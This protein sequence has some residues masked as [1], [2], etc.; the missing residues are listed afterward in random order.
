[1]N[2]T[3]AEATTAKTIAV[4]FKYVAP[5]TTLG[6]VEWTVNKTNADF[7]LPLGDI[8]A[9]LAGSTD[10]DLPSVVKVGS[11]TWADGKAL[12]E[13]TITVNGVKYGKDGTA[14]DESWITTID[15]STL[16]VKTVQVNMF[17]RLALRF[18]PRCTSSSVSITLKH[19]QQKKAIK[20]YW[21]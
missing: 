9:A 18:R 11:I 8:Q 17:Q 20:L 19:S 13:K 7:F 14:F 4:T 10:T 15:A 1:M 12:T 5:S 21:A 6:D 3:V 2:G 16:Y